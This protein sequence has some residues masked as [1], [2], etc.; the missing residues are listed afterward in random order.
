LGNLGDATPVGAGVHEMRIH[1]GAG[2]RVYFLDQGEAVL[3]LLCGGSTST[4][5]KAIARAQRLR[6]QV[7]GD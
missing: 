2:C 5:S 3:L 1:V 4:Q 7:E 6:A